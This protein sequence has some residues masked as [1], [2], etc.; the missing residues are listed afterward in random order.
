[1]L[2]PSAFAVP[3][4]LSLA[5]LG[6]GQD[7]PPPASAATTP[8]PKTSQSLPRFGIEVSAGTL[9]A[10]IQAATAVTHRSNVRFGFNYFSY[11][12]STSKDNIAYNGTLRLESGEVLYD[13]YLFGGVHISPGVMIYDGNQGTANAV[14]SGAQTFSL[15]GV[16]YYSANASPVTGTASITSRKVAP[17]LLIGF[18]NLLPRSTRHFTVNFD[19]GVVFQGSANAKLN[20]GGSTCPSDGVNNCVAISNNPAVQSNVVAEQTKINSSLGPFKFYPVI[21]LGFGYKF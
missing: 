20:L 14:V 13:Q 10:G 2:K 19:L 21:R 7:T 6:F 1:M 11:S 8:S 4:V 9:G 15:N 18:G 5:G 3:L 16:S 12:G 17:E